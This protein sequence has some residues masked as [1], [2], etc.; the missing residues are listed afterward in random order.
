MSKRKGEPKFHPKDLRWL[1]DC[2]PWL[3]TEEEFKKH[4]KL[5]KK[6]SDRKIGG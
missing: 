4:L 6:L 3:M 2:N 1:L 5:I